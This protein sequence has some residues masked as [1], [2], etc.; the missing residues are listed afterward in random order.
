MRIEKTARE[1]LTA[2]EMDLGDELVFQL[3]D[4]T[5]RSIVLEKA[6]AAVESTTLAELKKPQR[7]ARTVCRCHCQLRIDGVAVQLVRWVG[8]QRSFCEPRELFG[9]WLWFDATDGLFDFLTENHGPCKPRKKARFAV[10]DASR[11]ICPVLLHPWCPLPAG[12][13]RI[14]DCYDGTDSW[15]G[16][17]FG[18][19]A[20]GGLDINHPAGTPLWTPIV[21][22]DHA[23]YN[24][25]EKGENNN[26]WQGTHQWPDG[27]VWMLRTCHI[28]H[29]LAREHEP[30]PAGTQYANSAGMLTGSHEHSHFVF[31]V[32]EPGAAE[33]DEI[34]L[35]PWIL[36]RQMYRDRQLTM[37]E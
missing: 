11:R 15:M 17:Y 19:D 6:W 28:I 29:L 10:Q 31:G 32:R 3:A 23:F 22:D 34:L 8:D 24:H 12:G 20:H 2:V 33:G 36:F 35:D 18:A 14:E 9:L 27:S 30:L 5:R 25:V 7:G 4:G 26:R 16:P 1:T 13:I 21:I 37:A